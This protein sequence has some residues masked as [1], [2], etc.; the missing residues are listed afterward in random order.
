MKIN[1]QIENT[2]KVIKEI[3][4]GDYITQRGIAKN[5]G[6]SLGKVNYLIKSLV[7]K[8]IIKLENFIN[9]Q[10]K[11][12]YRYILTPRGIKEKYRVTKEFLK[13]KEHE[14]EVIKNEL[15][16]LRQEVEDL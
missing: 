2:Y 3:E 1:N 9:S 10:N 12:A 11:L 13:R 5:L 7:D 8:G 14:Y 16:K 15:E 6:Y 4:N